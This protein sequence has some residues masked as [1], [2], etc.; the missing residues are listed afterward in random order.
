MPCTFVQ[1]YKEVVPMGLAT[2][3]LSFAY[4]LRDTSLFISPSLWDFIQSL[5]FPNM[6]ISHHNKSLIYFLGDFVR[7][8]DATDNDG[9][10]NISISFLNGNFVPCQ[11]FSQNIGLVLVLRCQYGSVLKIRLTILNY[12]KSQ[13][14]RYCQ[15]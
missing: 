7:S 13:F 12:Y 9:V 10:I 1:G 5:S 2:L 11:I 6:L 8:R 15:C 3:L 14:W 4:S